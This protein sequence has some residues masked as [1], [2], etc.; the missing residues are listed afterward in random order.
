MLGVTIEANEEFV[1][2]VA[3]PPKK[4]NRQYWLSVDYDSLESFMESV[5]TG[6]WDYL[7]GGVIPESEGQSEL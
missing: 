6:V 4:I 3:S 5:E 1:R 7:C 2:D